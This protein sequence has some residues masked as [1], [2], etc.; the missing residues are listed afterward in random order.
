V[1]GGGREGGDNP[2]ALSSVTAWGQSRQWCV[3]SLQD[4]REDAVGSHMPSTDL[5]A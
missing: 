1:G 2:E 3:D 4:E 5:R